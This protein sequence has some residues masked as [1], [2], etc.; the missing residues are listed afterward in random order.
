MNSKAF[1]LAEYW[2]ALWAASRLAYCQ[3]KLAYDI[4]LQLTLAG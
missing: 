2:L 1:G 3:L 4:A